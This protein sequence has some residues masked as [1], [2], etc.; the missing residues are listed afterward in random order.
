MSPATDLATEKAPQFPEEDREAIASIIFIKIE[1]ERRWEERFTRPESVELLS[2]L[3]DE[4]LAATRAEKPGK[5]GDAHPTRIPTDI[6]TRQPPPQ[7][8]SAP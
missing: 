4:A 6:V 3:A 1:S 2:R 8:R 5:V 7:P